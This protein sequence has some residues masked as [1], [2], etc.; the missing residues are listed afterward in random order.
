MIGVHEHLLSKN[1][2]FNNSQY[3]L[4]L[5]TSS[6]KTDINNNDNDNYYHMNYYN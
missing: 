4:G 5:N 3:S 1:F 2:H 6:S